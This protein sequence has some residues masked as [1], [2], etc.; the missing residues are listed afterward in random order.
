MRAGGFSSVLI[1]F[2]FFPLC[3]SPWTV[4]KEPFQVLASPSGWLSATSDEKSKT[5]QL[6]AHALQFLCLKSVAPKFRLA[7]PA[8]ISIALLFLMH[9]SASKDI[10]LPCMVR[11]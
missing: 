2:F 10:D 9:F 5:Q 1:H 7:P 3:L 6:N 4:W 11:L 8:P